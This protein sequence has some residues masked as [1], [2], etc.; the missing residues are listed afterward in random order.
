MKIDECNRR[1]LHFEVTI[2]TSE[3]KNLNMRMKKKDFLSCAICVIYISK[4]QYEHAHEEEAF[5]Y[6]QSVP[7][8]LRL[9]ILANATSDEDGWLSEI[10]SH[11]RTIIKVGH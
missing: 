11:Y 9:R 7:P 4:L 1:D 6:C 10:L 2:W 8:W 5:S 3:E